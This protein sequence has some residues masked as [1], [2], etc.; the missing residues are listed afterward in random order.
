[1][2]LNDLAKNYID[3]PT[4]INASLLY[5]KTRTEMYRHLYA[6]NARRDQKDDAV[7]FALVKAFEKIHQY[8]P[9][10]AS[11]GVWACTIV[12]NELYQLSRKFLNR[13]EIN[14]DGDIEY[15]DK[16]LADKQGHYVLADEIVEYMQMSG[17]LKH[18]CHLDFVD[19]LSYNQI[20]EKRSMNLN[21]VK[22]CIKRS[23]EELQKKFKKKMAALQ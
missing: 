8:N 18:E 2:H 12:R 20:A 7:A 14:M 10:K 19:G 16:P 3:N 17:E 5:K 23:R 21:N 11:F 15:E 9:S 13:K 22:T 6:Y 4:P 1:M